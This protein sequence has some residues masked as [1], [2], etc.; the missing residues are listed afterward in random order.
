MTVDLATEF[1]RNRLMRVIE[2]RQ[3]DPD[4]LERKRLGICVEQECPHLQATAH[5][6][7]LCKGC[8]NP[9]KTRPRCPLGWW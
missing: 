7:E 4:A 1:T 8:A 2:R 9:F 5:R 6:C 3:M